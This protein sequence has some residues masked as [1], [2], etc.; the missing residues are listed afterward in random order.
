MSNN[1]SIQYLAEKAVAGGYETFTHVTPCRKCKTF[2]RYSRGRSG[3]VK[4]AKVAKKI[5]HRKKVNGGL[6]P[7]MLM[8]AKYLSRTL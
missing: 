6:T 5:Y 1:Q 4:C 8:S 2:E 7:V 3:C